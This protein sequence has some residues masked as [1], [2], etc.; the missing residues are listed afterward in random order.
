MDDKEVIVVSFSVTLL[1][2]LFEKKFLGDFPIQ[3]EML[4]LSGKSVITI[5]L[6]QR[7]LERERKRSNYAGS[8]VKQNKRASG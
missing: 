5:M 2:L 8:N 7:A 6:G 1:L 3:E 4:R